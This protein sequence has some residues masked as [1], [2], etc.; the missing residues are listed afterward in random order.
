[1]VLM[2]IIYS[3]FAHQ[4]IINLVLNSMKISMVKVIIELL[5]L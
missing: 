3:R 2:G 4:K 5:H 1:M